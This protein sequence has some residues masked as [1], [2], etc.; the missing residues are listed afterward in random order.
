MTHLQ[1]E[2]NII[3]KRVSILS[4]DSIA[5][6]PHE[7]L[8]ITQENPKSLAMN[9]KSNAGPRKRKKLGQVFLRS[10]GAIERIVH[11]IGFTT[12]DVVLEIGGGDGRV[13][14]IIAPLV[15]KLIVVELDERFAEILEQEFESTANVHIVRGD[16]LAR[17]TLDTVAGMIAEQKL[18]VYGSIPYN[19]TTPILHWLLDNT[20]LVNRASLLVQKE[21][22]QRIV[23]G[24]GSKAYG[25]TSVIMQLSTEVSL[26]PV[27]HRREFQPVPKVDSQLLHIRPREMWQ[28]PGQAFVDM[29]SVLFNQRRKQ[30]GNTLRLYLRHNLDDETKASLE[31][32]GFSLKSR[33]EEHSPERLLEL[34]ELLTGKSGGE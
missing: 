7:K 26:G 10:R 31:R 12:D 33:P 11:D 30:I 8:K 3:E 25:F 9:E 28:I 29:V 2:S 22:A 15:D 14:S 17:E 34:Y 27:V 32:N 5:L 20:A 19:I 18:L 21:V 23:A 24:P 4:G 16:I 13:S 6:F 1:P